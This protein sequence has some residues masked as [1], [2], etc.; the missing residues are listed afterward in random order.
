[1]KIDRILAVVF[2]ILLVAGFLWSERVRPP[3]SQVAR[4]ADAP[5]PVRRAVAESVEIPVFAEAVGTVRSRRQS[6]VAARVMAQVKEIRAAAGDAVAE[7]AVLMVL[8]DRDFAARKAQ[9]EAN[10]AARR[11]QRDEAGR[12]LER[13]RKLVA[14]DAATTQELD[15]LTFR[16]AAAEAA[17]LAAEKA[18]EEA[19]VQADHAVVRAPFDGIVL[20]KRVDPGD[21]AAPGVPLLT[22]YDPK[23][24]RLE[25]A[26]EE[27]L[28]GAV[29]VG[30][31]PKVRLDALGVE[32]DGRVSEV[33]PAVDPATRTGVVKIDL[34]ATPGLQPG[35][36]GRARIL[37]GRRAAVAVP[38]DALVRRGQLELVF[39]L[40]KGGDAARMAIVRA[41]GLLPDGERVEILSGLEAGRR[42]IVPV[43]GAEALRE[44]ARV[45]P[46]DQ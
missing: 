26:V 27:R 13:T 35:M 21:L 37:R 25:A 22:L 10:L 44:G 4:A 45:A 40:P 7:G 28:A 39:W 14:Q 16:F 23:G 8:D 24:L 12:E 6:D 5:L 42:I 36:F 19:V 38:G 33:V 18:L 2:G 31:T 20:E 43:P 34:P 32:L 15:I 17:A 30:D 11:R 1:M 3:Q 9:A 29:K 41:G 46:Q